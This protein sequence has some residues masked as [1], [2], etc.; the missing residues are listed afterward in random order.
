MNNSQWRQKT[1]I[2]RNKQ[3]NGILE[4]MVTSKGY[5]LT[6]LPPR[7]RLEEIEAPLLHR[8]LAFSCV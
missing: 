5:K 6:P 3:S 1:A 7:I 2:D 8:P 4:Q